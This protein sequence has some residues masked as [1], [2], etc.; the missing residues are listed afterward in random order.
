[1][2]LELSDTAILALAS[3]A[4]D[5]WSKAYDSL[6]EAKALTWE[7]SGK[8]C[9]KNEWFFYHT[10]MLE[11]SQKEMDEWAGIKQE[12]APALSILFS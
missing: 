7:T 4:H 9:P 2:Q 1:M 6:K 5:K 3:L 10:S 8:Y 11:N 12:L